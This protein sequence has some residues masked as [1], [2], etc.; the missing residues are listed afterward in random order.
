M[1][2]NKMK[3]GENLI[4]KCNMEGYI[5]IGVSSLLLLHWNFILKLVIFSGHIEKQVEQQQKKATKIK[6]SFTSILRGNKM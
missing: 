1:P 2:T 3:I 6:T 4:L 5:L